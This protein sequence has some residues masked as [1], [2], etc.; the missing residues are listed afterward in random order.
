MLTKD[1]M[2]KVGDVW[3]NPYGDKLYIIDTMEDLVHCVTDFYGGRAT[4]Y[5]KWKFNHYTYLGKSKIN[6]ND[7]FE[8]Q[9]E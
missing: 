5:L 6:N 9:D 8:V 1:K 2:P 3:V 7:L 4:T